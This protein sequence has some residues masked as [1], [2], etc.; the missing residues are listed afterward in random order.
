MDGIE[1]E[2]RAIG[3]EPTPGLFPP[4]RTSKRDLPSKG[5]LPERIPPE[6]LREIIFN[7]E[8]R[9]EGFHYE[10]WRAPGGKSV[11]V[12]A[13]NDENEVIGEYN[14]ETGELK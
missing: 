1:E 4:E 13:Y 8:G 5:G 9:F 10:V 3:I 2:L 14:P 11:Q 7:G 6:E 12:R